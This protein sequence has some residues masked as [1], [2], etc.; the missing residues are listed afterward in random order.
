LVFGRRKWRTKSVNRVIEEIKMLMSLG[1][2]ELHIQDDGFTSNLK[3]AKDICR[4]LLTLDKKI[5]WELYN[6]IRVDRIDDEFLDLAVRSGCYRIKYGVE[7]GDQKVLDL[8]NKKT[9]LHQIREAFR[10]TRKHGI[11]SVALFMVGLPPATKE[12]MERSIRFGLEIKPDYLRAAFFTPYP[13]SFFYDK[14]EKEN[15]IRNN[16]W[17]DYHFH[18]KGQLLFEHPNLSDQ[19]IISAYNR[20]HRKFYMRFGYFMDRLY[21]G[22]RRGSFLRDSIYFLEKF[23]LLP[24]VLMLKGIL[25]RKTLESSR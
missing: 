18:R 12:S 3:R 1:F 13:G 23:I 25:K 11:E 19:E 14:L 16:N 22:V 15:R 6:G 5:P 24:L 2:N 21:Y 17:D 9:K 4:H 7:S 10:M 20:F 8:I